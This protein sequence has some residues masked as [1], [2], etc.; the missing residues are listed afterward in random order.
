MNSYSDATTQADLPTLWL[1]PKALYV[2]QPEA[3]ALLDQVN[4]R[5]WATVDPALL[6]IIRLR[7]AWL[8]GNTAGMRARSSPA[9]IPEQKVAE[10]PAYATSP[11]FSALDRDGV[12]FAEQFVMDV[13]GTSQESLDALRDQLGWDRLRDFV[14][15]V[16]LVEFTQ[17][18]QLVAQALLPAVP[19]LSDA[20]RPDQRQG[21]LRELLESYQDAVVRSTALDPVTTELV[22]LRCARTHNCR[23]CQTLRLADAQTAGVDS[24]MTS[25]IDFYETSDLPESHKI[26]LRITDAFIIRPDALSADI[27]GPARAT[28][29]PEQLAELCLDIT[30]WSTQKIHV[31]LGTDGADGLPINEDGVVMFGFQ[32][33]GRVAGYWADPEHPVVV[34]TGQGH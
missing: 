15:S 32:E 29:S 8:L 3:T 4:Q 16:Y 23:I 17:R 28:F 34:P 2:L 6:E 9:R 24:E 33:D 30:K 13:T 20:G 5:V 7:I 12:A 11:S 1:L 21:S 31:A 22:R 26:A 18:L 14:T 10:L 19:D 27:V 25:K